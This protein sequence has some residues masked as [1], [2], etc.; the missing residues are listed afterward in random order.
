MS[1]IIQGLWIGDELSVMERL[2][3]ASFLAHGH[4]YHLYVYDDVR[5]IPP[6]TVLRDASEVLPSS[7]IFTYKRRNSYA[8]FSNF[9]RYKLLLQDGGWW[10]DA[11][12]VCL[13]P[14]DFP[15]E[16]V[17]STEIDQGLEVINSGAIKV[18]PHCEIMAYAWNVCQSKDPEQLVWGETGPALMTTAV[19]SC[20]L[21][22]HKKKHDV[23]CPIPFLDWRDVLEPSRCAVM[24]EGTYAIHLWN[25]MWRRAGVDKNGTYDPDCLYERLKARYLGS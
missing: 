13:K 22:S 11:D 24:N 8:G 4:P 10:C 16:Y 18:P 15:D 6:G 20:S 14:F 23:F 7:A 25:E 1:D 17:F 19:A 9:F 3:I 21:E 12:L 5:G 2:S